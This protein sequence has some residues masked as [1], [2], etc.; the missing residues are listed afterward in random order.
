MID[1]KVLVMGVAGSGKSTLAALLSRTLGATLIEGDDHHLPQSQDR[2]RCGIALQDAEREPWVGRL[3]DL[4]AAEL[5]PTV[6]ICSASKRRYRERLRTAVPALRT[7]YID[8]QSDLSLARVAA[9]P[10]HVFPP[11][12]VVSRFGALEVP[13]GEPAVLQLSSLQPVTPSCKPCSTGWPNPRTPASRHEPH[14]Q[15]L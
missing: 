8:I 1:P 6:L 5:G 7:V 12:L 9:R 15:T 3:G 10:G 14:R 13:T 4:L 11:E 2:M